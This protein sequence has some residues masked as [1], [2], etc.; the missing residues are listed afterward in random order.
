MSGPDAA[1]RRPGNTYW[2]LTLSLLALLLVGCSALG[3]L[4]RGSGWWFAMAFVAAVVL[5]SAA[6]LRRLGTPASVVPVASVGVLLALVTLIFGAGSGLLWLV[7]TPDTF[8]RFHELIDAGLGSIQQQSTPAEA[9][10]GIVFLLACGAGLIAILMDILAIT[11]RWPALA[12]LP[13]LVPVAVPGLL[14]DGGADFFA[15]VLVAAA[16]LVVLRVDVRLRRRQEAENPDVGDDAPRVF[17]PVRRRGPGPLWGAMMVGS[18]GIVSA[19]VLSSVTPS[20]SE[21]V[22]AGNGTNSMLFGTGVSPMVDLGQDL[23]RPQAGP[24][25]HYTT[26]AAQLPYFKLLTLDRFVGTTWTASTTRPNPR[27]SVE[28]IKKPE[29]LAADVK[30]EETRTAVVIDEVRTSW[31][32]APSPAV[33]VKGLSGSWY[34]DSSTRSIASSDATTSGQ[35]YAVKALQLA[36]T[37]EQLRHAS[38]S[39]PPQV[40]QYL[41]LPFPRPAIIDQTASIVTAGAA[42]TYDAAV[43]LQDYLR[44]SAFTYDTDAPVKAGYDG[45]GAD[46]IGTFLEV[47]RGYCVHFASAMAI[48]AR[49]LGIPSRLALGYLP[50]VKSSDSAEGEGRYNVSSHDLHSWPELYFTGVG[51][52]Q[53]EPTPGRGSVP[54]Y[55]TPAAAHAAE[56]APGATLPT[57]APRTNDNGLSSAPG[58]APG[59]SADVPKANG[60][61]EALLMMVLIVCLLA[62]PGAAR[63]IR[64]LLRLRT[65]ATGRRGPASAWRELTDT[66]IDHGV[67]VRDTETPRELAARLARLMGEREEDTM[68]QVSLQRLLVAEERS[69]YDRPA[70]DGGPGDVDAGARRAADLAVVLRAVHSAAPTGARWRAMLL[71]ASLWPWGPARRNSRVSIGA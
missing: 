59:S 46:V 32:P 47:K 42:S 31:L 69:S 4:L 9:A 22:L 26:S 50:G 49:S 39:Y 54:D 56:T 7:P 66:A 17:A 3:P 10:E 5:C 30:T 51:W 11:L 21:G 19:V 36:P 23:R 70:H 37:A 34:W 65:L 1:A 52:V 62:A 48:M 25:L 68:P 45:G 33:Q 67:P 2:P 58:A 55:A 35:T 13:V 28:R 29:G 6:V 60:S 43:A 18:V 40:A 38:T 24:A 12:G 41:D 61:F 14:I 71:P 53:F 16:Y 27:N 64:R 63:R 20:L 15:L 8:G 44:G 57:S